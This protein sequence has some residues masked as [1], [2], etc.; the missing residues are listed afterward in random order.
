MN[1]S[2]RHCRFSTENS[3]KPSITQRQSLQILKI[4]TSSIKISPAK[5]RNPQDLH[6]KHQ[7]FTRKSYKFQ[8]FFENTRI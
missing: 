6:P 8:G 3:Q 1:I 5:A 2:K 7:H 4:Y